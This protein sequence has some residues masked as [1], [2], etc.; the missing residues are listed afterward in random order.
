MDKHRSVKET[1]VRYLAGVKPDEYTFFTCVRNPWDIIHSDYYFCLRSFK[2]LDWIKNTFF[3]RS[4]QAENKWT[5]KLERTGKMDS[6][7]DFVRNEYI[8]NGINFWYCYCQD[9]DKRDLVQSVIRFEDM[10]NDWNRFCIATGIPITILP[11]HNSTSAKPHYTLEY[12]PYTRS[13]VASLNA[14]LIERIGYEF[15]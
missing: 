4:G 8:E 11:V 9:D 2:N 15:K 5:Q 3:Q 14:D 10:Q 12:T 7:D 13:A 1:I 6:F